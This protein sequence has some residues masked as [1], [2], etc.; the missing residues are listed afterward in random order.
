MNHSIAILLTV[1]NRKDYTLRCLQQLFDQQL[2]EEIAVDIF[3]TDGGSKDGTVEAVRKQF[4]DVHI[5]VKDGVFWNRGMFASWEMAISKQQYDFYLWLNDDTYLYQDCIVKLLHASTIKENEAIIVGSTV[6]TTQQ[7]VTYGGRDKNGNLVPLNG[8]LAEVVHFNGNIVL[9]P[10]LVYKVLGNLDYYYC[11]SKG[12]FDYAIRAHKA[13]IK[14][15]QI[16]IVLGECDSHPRI[17]S[18]CDSQVS[19]RKRWKMM[20]LPN[21]MPPKEIFH[22]EKQESWKKAIIHF[23]TIYL[24]CLFPRIWKLKS[25]QYEK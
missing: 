25:T 3:I 1:F 9:V 22:L 13:G 17:D 21:G 5:Q 6:D 12:D 16:G 19:L 2:P 14:I 8:Q 7:Q 15:Y 10:A 23:F 24:R 20:H 11:H 4:P 18:W